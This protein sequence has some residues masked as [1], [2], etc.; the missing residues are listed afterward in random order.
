MKAVLIKQRLDSSDDRLQ[1]L[2]M[3]MAEIK[4]KEKVIVNKKQEFDSLKADI[5]KH[6]GQDELIVKQ[7]TQLQ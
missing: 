1:S 4:Y 3:D 5:Q 2:M 6:K 7:I